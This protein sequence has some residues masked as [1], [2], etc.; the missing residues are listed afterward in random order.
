MTD[1]AVKTLEHYIKGPRKPVLQEKQVFLVFTECYC[2]PILSEFQPIMT[3][4]RE[5]AQVC[6]SLPLF[7]AVVYILCRC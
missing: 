4:D 2:H 6:Y 7:A 3:K 1:E 5:L